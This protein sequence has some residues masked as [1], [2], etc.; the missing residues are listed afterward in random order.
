MTNSPLALSPTRPAFADLAPIPVASRSW[1][2]A[3]RFCKRILDVVV[4][5]VA[6]VV[7]APVLAVIAVL[8][9]CDSA[10]GVLYRQQRI[11]RD[12]EPFSML[13]FRSMSADADLRRE[14]LTAGRGKGLFKM[15][16]DPRITRVGHVL[17]RYS[18]DE[19]PQLVNVLRGDMSLVGPRPALPSEVAEYDRREMGRLAATPGLSG[20][21]Q[22]SGRSDL[23]WDDGIRLD[24]FY[25]ENRSMALDLRILWRTA[26][27]VTSSS[28]AY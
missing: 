21:W 23:G 14:A 13:K 20:L 22:V 6:L 3:D 15:V 10:G 26:K 11:G 16:D 7:L 4:A 1:D 25:V 24:L 12:G 5:A 8:I 28:G 18:L 2:D 17:R 27:A 9:A 19:L